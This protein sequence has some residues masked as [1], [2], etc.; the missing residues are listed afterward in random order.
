MHLEEVSNELGTL[1]AGGVDGGVATISS[2]AGGADGGMACA[3]VCGDDDT[4]VPKK[5]SIGVLSMLSS[6]TAASVM[7]KNRDIRRAFA[8][9]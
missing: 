4:G 5:G 7:I 6:T 9:R 2:C 3:S 8:P 1:C